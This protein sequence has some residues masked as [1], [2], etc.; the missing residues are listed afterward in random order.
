MAPHVQTSRDMEHLGRP[1]PVKEGVAALNSCCSLHVQL[2]PSVVQR[3][4]GRNA[5]KWYWR[6][7]FGW[8]LGPG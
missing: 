4:E 3:N 8:A 7:H 5:G 2:G 1:G 6:L